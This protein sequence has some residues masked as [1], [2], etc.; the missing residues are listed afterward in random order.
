M[1]LAALPG[2]TGLDT[3]QELGS[4]VY[5]VRPIGRPSVTAD[6]TLYTSAGMAPRKIVSQR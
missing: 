2:D 5:Y 3:R 6:M 4:S 1:N